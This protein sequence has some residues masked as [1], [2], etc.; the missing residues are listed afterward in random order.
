MSLTID[1]TP[2]EEAQFVDYAR[3]RGLEPATLAKTLITA[4][5]PPVVAGVEMEENA[6]A[7]LGERFGYLF[8]TVEGLPPDLSTNPKYMEDFG[9]DSGEIRP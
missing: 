3:Q 7:S 8:G 5:L 4:P 2:Q 6:G 1:L 9:K